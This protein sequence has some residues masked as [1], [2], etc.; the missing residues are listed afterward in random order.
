MAIEDTAEQTEFR[1]EIRSWLAQNLPRDLARKVLQGQK[2]SKEEHV[3]WQAVQHAQGWLAP[4]WPP[5]W[6]GPGWG[7]VERL[8][9][10]EEANL[11]GMPRA[12]LPGIDLLGPVLIAFGTEK[13]KQRFLPPILNSEHWWCQGFSEPGAGSDLA[14]LSTTAV[15]D[16]DDYVINGTKLWTSHAQ[17]SNWIMC[18]ARTSAEEKKQA[19][20]SFILVDMEQ[21]GVTVTPIITIG[22]VHAV[23]QVVLDD[24]RAPVANRIGDEGQ[25]WDITKFLLGSERILGAW[26]GGSV[27]LLRSLK[28][29]ARREFPDGIPADLRNR[30]AMVEIELTSVQQI[31]QGVLADEIAGREPGPEVSVLKIK[32]SE[33][34]QKLTELLMQTSGPLAMIDPLSLPEHDGSIVPADMAYQTQQY[35]DRRKM[36]IYGGAREIQHNIIAR[37]ILR[38]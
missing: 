12:N 17:V 35:L 27:Q 26:I 19:G 11:A 18:L 3:S 10:D 28:A 2:V 15:R 16:G 29:L 8:I 7:P 23:N 5:E 22:G 6:G 14:A 36:T 13:Q 4:S 1:E 38:G 32:G 25:A 34:Q 37:R 20:I 24:A 33:V 21:P 30:I 31:A 9:F